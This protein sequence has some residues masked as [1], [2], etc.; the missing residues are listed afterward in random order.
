[1]H[2]LQSA[3]SRKLLIA[4]A[5][6]CLAAA[7]QAQPIAAPGTEGYSVV[8]SG[9]EV[10]ATYE[11]TTASFSNDL[12]L[13]G[14]FIFNNQT[15]PVGTTVS[16]GTFAANTELIFE[17]RVENGDRF[18]SGPSSRNADG[19]SHARV[20]ADWTTPG[21]TLV[22]FEDLNGGPYDYNDLSFSFSNTVS[23]PTPPAV[24]E[25]KTWALMAAGLAMAGVIARR[26]RDAID[27]L[28]A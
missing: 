10:F 14:V 11:G 20:E 19:G 22:S 16:L 3:R 2:R 21:T 18:Y 26:R 5:A 25:P 1:M 9:G 17:L 27:Q 23:V 8:A 24:P 28:E 12:Y 4:A 15:T 6:A 7:A 13:N